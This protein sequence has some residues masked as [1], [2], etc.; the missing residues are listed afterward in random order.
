M[1]YTLL[2]DSS[3]WIMG[4]SKIPGEGFYGG[5][6]I[7]TKSEQEILLLGHEMR[8]LRFNVKDHTFH[9]LP[10]YL[11]V[12]RAAHRCALIP[13]TNKIMITG[14]FDNGP[15]D[16]TEILDTE[17]GSVTMASPMNFKKG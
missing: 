4:K 10:S 16:S 17:D 5:C 12:P 2:K 14:G 15:S 11:N 13:N 8:I 3:E 9:E 6:V 7:A 1:F